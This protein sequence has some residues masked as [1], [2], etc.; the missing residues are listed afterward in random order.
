M[1]TVNFNLR[2]ENW[3]LSVPSSLFSVLVSEW[4]YLPS[5]AVPDMHYVAILHDVILPFE[6]ERSFGAGI[7]FGAGFQ[8]LV[9]TDGFGANEMLLQIGVEGASGFHCTCADRDGPGAAFVFAGGE[10]GN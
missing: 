4:E 5:P 7:G 3:G 10:K 2:T 6:A 9:P 8:Q 1:N